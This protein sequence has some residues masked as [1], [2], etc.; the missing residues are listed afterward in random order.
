MLIIFDWLYIAL[1][2][3]VIPGILF[4]IYASAKVNSAY[5]RAKEMHNAKGVKS[6]DMCRRVLD[7]AG[8]NH[9]QITRVSGR[10]TDH[11][12]TKTKTIAISESNWD[13]TSVAALG[14]VAHEIGHALQH[15]EKYF[16]LKIQQTTGVISRILHR[17]FFIFL[18]AMILIDVMMIWQGVSSTPWFAIGILGVYGVSTLFTILTLPVEYNAT[19]RTEKVLVTTGLLT[20]DEYDEARR[21]LNAAALTYVAAAVIS[22]LQFLRI[23]IWVLM[24]TGKVG[25]RR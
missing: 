17:W 10:L 1:G 5:Q 23:L 25:R 12:N 21:V 14:V 18:I 13:S 11:Y 24:I 3:I 15:K 9:V 6:Q 8:L 7:A 20:D 16:P 22:F 19:R 4:G 2:I